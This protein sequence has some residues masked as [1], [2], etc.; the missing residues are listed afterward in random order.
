MKHLGVTRSALPSAFTRV[1]GGVFFLYG[2]DEFR[3]EEAVRALIDAHLDPATRDFNFDPLRGKDVEPETLASILATPP[4]MAEWRVVVLRETEALASS[5]IARDILL[6]VAR[7]P[8]P[9]LALILSCTV[10]SGS[11][12]KFYT[13]LR[14]LAHAYEFQPVTDADAPG[15]LMERAR[16]AHG[17]EMDADAA[18]RLAAAVGTD[19]GILERELEKLT[20]FVGERR[21]ITVPDI[22]AAGTRLPKQDRWQW[23]DLVGERR[24]A[25]ALDGLA[26]LWW[27]GES[28]AGLVVGLGTQLLRIGVALDGGSGRLEAILPPHQR[29]LARRLTGQARRWTRAELDAALDGLLEVDRMIKSTGHDDAHFLE[30]WLLTLM[31]REEAA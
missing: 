4:M 28:A 24:F 17:V 8:P 7:D 13:E 5:K 22:E 15:W 10:P 9:G 6:D 3:K 2:G 14:K 1:R 20:E 25:E 30:S 26:A 27:Q 19:L 11:K 29:W 23:L 21:R 31:A 12:A 16:E 18:R